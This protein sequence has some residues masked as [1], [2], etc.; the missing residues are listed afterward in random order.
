[1][2]R[3]GA[4]VSIA[5]SDQTAIADAAARIERDMRSKVMSSAVDVRSGDAIQRWISATADL[6][7]G[8]DALLT[9][10]GGPPAGA[11]LSFDDA[12]WKDAAELLL[13]QYS[14]DGQGRRPQNTFF[15]M[16]AD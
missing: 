9:N 7:G 14:A 5:S 8:V 15:T 1:M 16:A 6:F 11:T 13:V 10:P 4:S 12:A 3:E 2:A